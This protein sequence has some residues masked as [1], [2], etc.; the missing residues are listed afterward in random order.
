MAFP[1]YL[2]KSFTTSAQPLFSSVFVSYLQVPPYMCYLLLSNSNIAVCCPSCVL[3][4]IAG[5][6][7]EHITIMEE[8]HPF[9]KKFK[10]F[11]VK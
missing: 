11:G 7:H 4:L 9:Q 10:E 8:T 1:I 5:S 6:R 3:G 2:K